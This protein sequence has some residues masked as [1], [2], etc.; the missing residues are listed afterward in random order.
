[1]II[2]SPSMGLNEYQMSGKCSVLI[3]A[4]NGWGDVSNVVTSS[5]HCDLDSVDYL[6]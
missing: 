1:M 6:H 5:G 3:R 2:T 4:E